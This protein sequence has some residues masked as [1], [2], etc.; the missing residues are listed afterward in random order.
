MVEV[1]VA[2]LVFG[3][4]RPV[5]EIC[6]LALRLLGEEVVHKSDGELASFAQLADDFVVLGIVLEPAACINR[7]SDPEPIELTH[8]VAGP[9][10]L[11]NLPTLPNPPLHCPAD[12]S[13]G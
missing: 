12:T 6:F 1:V 4:A 11:T 8:E 10:E 7:A 5:Q 9:R 3:S 13:T 2:L